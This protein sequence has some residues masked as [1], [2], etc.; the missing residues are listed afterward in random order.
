[1]LKKYTRC[2][3]KIRLSLISLPLIVWL[4]VNCKDNKSGSGKPSSRGADSSNHSSIRNSAST[5]T[6]GGRNATNSDPNATNGSPN[7][8]KSDPISD[9]STSPSSGQVKPVSKKM[10]KASKK[11]GFIFLSNIL[12][13]ISNDKKHIDINAKDSSNSNITAL[14]Q[15]VEME[16]EAIIQFLLQQG[17]D[18]NAVDNS[19][20]TPLHSAVRMDK[21]G[22]IQL[23][24]K[25]ANI[26]INLQ[27]KVGNTVLHIVAYKGNRPMLALLL[28]H[29]KI[30]INAQASV[31]GDT[32]LHIA[33]LRGHIDIVKDLLE[34]GASVDITDEAGKTPLDRAANNTIRQLIGKK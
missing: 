11:G 22:A 4:L 1:M 21:L 14:H 20:F 25:N 27:D 18:V 7:P 32:P 13:G 28:E 3:C 30:N 31:G 16:D 9:P 34:K 33:A 15:A 10:I 5:L 8:T 12:M 29:K 17:A 23:L 6:S 2:A 19:G 26:D 24:V